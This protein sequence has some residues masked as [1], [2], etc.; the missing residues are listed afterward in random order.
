MLEERSRVRASGAELLRSDAAL[1]NPS[2]AAALSAASLRTAASWLDRAALL[3]CAERRPRSPSALPPPLLT[4]PPLPPVAAACGDASVPADPVS[5]SGG[6]GCCCWLE[7]GD[8]ALLPATPA[9]A[10]APAPPDAAPPPPP[11]GVPLGD[12]V[13]S[14]ELTLDPES[15]RS[16]AKDFAAASE[17]PISFWSADV[18]QVYS[19]HFCDRSRWRQLS[20]LAPRATISCDRQS[21]AWSLNER[22]SAQQQV[23]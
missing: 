10:I 7:V 15:T 6:C 3:S 9:A 12:G 16:A 17:N 20:Q 13:A 4:P 18:S 8:T 19:W 23:H 2:P 21:P 1:S 14:G 5:F 11:T 22:C